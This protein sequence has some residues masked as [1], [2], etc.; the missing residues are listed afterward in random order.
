M[1]PFSL[2]ALLISSAAAAQGFPS[3]ESPQTH[4][5]DISADGTR[6]AVVNTPDNRIAVLS[7]ANP[8]RPSL[9]REIAVGLEPVAVRFR[10][11]DEAWVVNH[12]SD[13]VSVV[14][15]ARGRRR[16][17]LA[18][19]RRTRGRRIRERPRVRDDRDAAQRARVR[20]GHAKPRRHRRPV[21]RRTA[22]GHG[23]RRRLDRLHRRTQVRQQH[24]D[25]ARE[26][27]APAAAADQSDAASRPVGR[28]DRR[29]RRPGV[30]C[31]ARRVATRLR[32]VRDR[33]GDPRDHD[34]H[35]AV[36][37]V[38]FGMAVHPTDGSVWATNTEARNL[39]RFEPALRGHTVDHR[40]TRIASDG[41]LTM[42][43]LNPGID[44]T[45]LPNPA[46]LAN[47]LAQ[48]TDAVFS[49]DGSQLFVAAFGTDRI[50]VL[51]ASGN[52]T[53]R[54]AIGNAS[55]SREIRGPRGLVH[56][57]TASRLYV[58][59]RL[60]K[61]PIGCRH[62]RGDADRRAPAGL[63]SDADRAQGGS[64]FSVR[65]EAVRQRHRVV[66]GLPHRRAHRQP[67]LG[68]R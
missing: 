47:A 7:L 54:I 60:A 11:L 62:E 8:S 64:R 29:Q 13:S 32:R 49:P 31:R 57:P 39:V 2:L 19:R 27:R 9:L 15:L 14:D 36:G 18:A 67:R 41:S 22:L 20:R 35:S 10:T 45:V 53:A 52:V 38:L 30:D 12:L 44:Y 4:P 48:P 3:F 46:A 6:L 5:V 61:L 24:D 65:R 55:N 33:R 58:L 21:L 26:P 59:N 16:R 28:A 34:R 63:R 17:H 56:H 40:V 68:P 51:D 1:R 42:H 23:Q 43:D 66:R 50:G 25:R 37:T